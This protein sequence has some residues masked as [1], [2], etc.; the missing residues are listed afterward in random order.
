MT[1]VDKAADSVPGARSHGVIGAVLVDHALR[2]LLNGSYRMVA[3]AP[4][5]RCRGAAKDGTL[6]FA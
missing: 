4:T 1:A 3:A 5:A 2:R 6:A